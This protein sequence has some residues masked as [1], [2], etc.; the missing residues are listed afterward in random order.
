MS[1]TIRRTRS[2]KIS[3]RNIVGSDWIRRSAFALVMVVAMTAATGTAEA[4]GA[5]TIQGVVTA[6]AVPQNLVV[7]GAYDATTH[8]FVKA[9]FTDSSGFYQI[10]GLAPGSYHVRFTGTNPA[11]LQQWWDHSPA[12]AGA[13]IVT[14]TGSETV[15]ASSDLINAPPTTTQAI[16]GTVTNGATPL[17][18]AVVSAYDATSHSLVA[19]SFT[20][21][22][23]FFRIKGLTAGSYHLRF[24]GTT[25]SSL[26]QYYDHKASMTSAAT[27]TLAVGQTLT[28]SANL[29]P[30][31]PPP[32]QTIQGTVTDGGVP[33]NHVVVSAYDATTHSFAT[34]A[35]TDSTGFYQIHGLPAGS[36][37]LRFTGTTPS[38][39][40]QYYD[41][42][43]SITQATTS[44][45]AVGQTLNVS[46]NLAP[47]A[48]PP[49]QSIEGTVTYLGTAQ[50]RI[51][52]SAFDATTHDYVAGAFTDQSGHYKI[53]GLPIGYYHIR[54]TGTH[55]DCLAQFWDHQLMGRQFMSLATT[56]PLVGYGQTRTVSTDLAP[57]LTI[58]GNLT[59][60]GVPVYRATASVYNLT[61]H[62]FVLSVYS[63][64]NGHYE[65]KNLI[66]GSYQLRFTP[67]NHFP[68]SFPTQYWLRRPNATVA[69]SITVLPL[70]YVPLQTFVADSE[71]ATPSVWP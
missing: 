37:H 48:P 25:P 31:A 24:T 34:A 46:S 62:A 1:A 42:K 7:V 35:F 68:G 43:A 49:T 54:F 18:Q 2:S 28:V 66:P 27:S 3:P 63:D 9:V 30:T 55:P 58:L 67:D 53:T 21:S 45:L 57:V 52:V 5:P 70:D 36:Y 33:L 69:T 19:A 32:T 15:T 8:S 64:A 71:L 59:N 16:E 50:D 17:N 20:D 61:T 11:S 29:A 14:L 13:A 6:S 10:V 23:G 51:V 40:E 65:L 56:T 4:W 47:T 12:M 38:S 26:E 44:T 39:L 60:N 22:A 41:H